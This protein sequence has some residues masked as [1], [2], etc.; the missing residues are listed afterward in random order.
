[1]A[2]QLPNF[3]VP[4]VATIADPADP[5]RAEIVAYRTLTTQWNTTVLN[6]LSICNPNHGYAVPYPNDPPVNADQAAR[7]VRLQE[8]RQYVDGLFP[9]YAAGYAALAQAIAAGNQPAPAVAA[10]RPRLPKTALPDKFVGKSSA[11][12]RHFLQ[13]CEKYA[14]I[15][16]FSS[17]EKEIR[18][19]LQLMKGEASHWRDAQL[20]QYKLVPPPAHLANRALF[21]VEFR[22]RWTDPYESEKALDR[23]LKG[24]I[25]QRGS[26]KVYN[27]QFNKALSLTTETGTNASILRSYETG[28]KS[29]VRNAAVV[30]LLA[31][32]NISFPDRQ[33]LMARLDETLMQTRAQTNPTIPRRYTT[34]NPAANPPSGSFPQDARAPTPNTPAPRN[35]IPIEDEA[36]HQYT[37]LTPEEREN[38]RQI[39]G[40]FRC[41]QPGHISSQCPRRIETR[42]NYQALQEASPD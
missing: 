28:L 6:Q 12:A 30:A 26:V 19:M 23:I 14:A 37:R 2:F 11:A 3:Q 15:C 17:P 40:C 36:T 41:R 42:L 9:I 5:T 29:T 31:T 34:L 21:V 18:W 39:G 16:P 27:D 32:P 7:I 22:A 38:L 24:Y 1:M 13:Q 25:V 8:I 35:Q 4:P 10:P 20:D 33:K